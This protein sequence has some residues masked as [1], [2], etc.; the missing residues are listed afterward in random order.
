MECSLA[1]LSLLHA[2]EVARDAAD[3]RAA[4]VSPGSEL[5]GNAD[6]FSECSVADIFS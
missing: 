1:L 5:L 6:A 2:C 3:S 4:E